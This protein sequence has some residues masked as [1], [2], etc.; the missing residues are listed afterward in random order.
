MSS[1]LG[2][3]KFRQCAPAAAD[4]KKRIAGLE[5][6]FLTDNCQLV[7]LE[8][9]ETLFFV[10][11]ADKTGSVDHAGT[12]EPTVEV[13]APV[14]VVADLFFVFDELARQMRFT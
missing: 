10:N 8:L 4:V 13:I 5:T 11:V 7:V 14:V 9:F 1:I 12:E 2:A 3:G 6:N